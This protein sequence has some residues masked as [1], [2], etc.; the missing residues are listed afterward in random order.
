MNKSDKYS[1]ILRGQE[2][3]SYHI[4]EILDVQICP[5][6]LNEG[7]DEVRSE[8]MDICCDSL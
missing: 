3:R 1:L 5:R 6:T 4:G 7:D 2:T 8:G